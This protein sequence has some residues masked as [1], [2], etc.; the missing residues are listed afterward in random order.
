MPLQ[1][2]ANVE[3]LCQLAQVSRSG[4]YRYLRN[5]WPAEE[6]VNRRSAIQDV[7]LEHHWRYGYRRVTA[8]LR[9][10]GMIVNHKLV[11]RIMRDDNLLTVRQEPS[12]ASQEGIRAVQS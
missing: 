11:A 6:E 5:G 12:P 2:G 9:Q 7:V 8:Q 3:R 10:C 1:G 4:F